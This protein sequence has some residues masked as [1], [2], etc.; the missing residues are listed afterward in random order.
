MNA[1]N[2]IKTHFDNKVIITFIIV[3]ILSCGLLAFKKSNEV[4]C[5]VFD[6]DT[7]IKQYMVGDVITFSE[8]SGKAY[9]WRWYF[10]DGS[11]I[12]YK[13]KELHSFSKAGN[14][15]VK[16]LVNGTCEIEKTI[17]VIPKPVIESKEPVVVDFESPIRVIQGELVQ[18]EDKTV[19]A[20]TW[21]WKF[22]ESNH[23]DSKL[24]NPKYKFNSI[25]VKTISLVVNGD[26]KN[27]VLRDIIVM[28]KSEKNTLKKVKVAK[29]V[30][31][32]TIT[33]VVVEEKPQPI[34]VKSISEAEL[35]KL[36]YSVSDNKISLINFRNQFCEGNVPKFKVNT[37]SRF[38]TLDQFYKSIKNK[39]IKIREVKINKD[40]DQC[41]ESIYVN[42]KYKT[43]F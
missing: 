1:N 12:S 20:E 14:F 38:M 11:D 33:N 23:V 17:K 3:F 43:F 30:A 2:Q 37:D 42:F 27:R 21:E 16:L 15:K 31:K 22:G 35:E 41:I 6:Y 9:S 10:G 18:F 8:T 19:G 39:G 36:L 40:N 24:K 13:S 28:A 7:D 4:D 34:I 32:D 25:G 26:K 5:S 29:V